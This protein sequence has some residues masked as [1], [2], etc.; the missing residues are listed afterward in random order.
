MQLRAGTLPPVPRRGVVEWL[1]VRFVVVRGQIPRGA[2]APKSMHPTSTP[3]RDAVLA[4]VRRDVAR[5]RAIGDTLGAS[6]RD[7]LW[8]PNPFRPAWRYTY[9]ESLRMQAVHARHHGALVGEFMNK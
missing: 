1:F 7:R 4:Q 2:P 9:P 6:E 5:Y 3:D 8:V